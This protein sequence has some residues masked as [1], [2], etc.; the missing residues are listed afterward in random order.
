[1]H[2]A[3]SESITI[4]APPAKVWFALTD[5]ASMIKW[6]SEADMQL[7]IE[8]SW[9]EGAEIL[10]KGNFHGEFKNQGRILKNLPE[11]QLRYSHLS[12]LSMLEDLP[13][14]YTI[15]NFTLTSR[16]ARTLLTIVISNFPTESIRKHLEL[17]WKVTIRNIKEYVESTL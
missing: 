15:M 4:E 5:P 8:T 3:I 17:Y 1:M 6:M 11:K 13:A 14:N 16:N 12:S 7:V 9:Q 2:R 10:F